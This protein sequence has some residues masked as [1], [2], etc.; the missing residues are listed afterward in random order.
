[1]VKALGRCG[2]KH[3]PIQDIGAKS[4]RTAVLGSVIFLSLMKT[5]RTTFDRQFTKAVSRA[6]KT[7]L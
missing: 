1:M 3:P 5:H 4:K 6:T 7:D 2:V